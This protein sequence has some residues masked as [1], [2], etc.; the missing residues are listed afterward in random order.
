MVFRSR[1]TLHKSLVSVLL[2]NVRPTDFSSHRP[3][4]IFVDFKAF[5]LP[6]VKCPYCKLVI[7]FD[8]C[9][10]VAKFVATHIYLAEFFEPSK[11]IW[12]PAKVMRNTGTI[13]LSIINPRNLTLNNVNNLTKWSESFLSHRLIRDPS[14]KQ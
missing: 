13:H 12:K 5:A 1:K 6:E 7:E 11:G 14:K 10:E 8:N 3:R 2:C 9:A 4:S